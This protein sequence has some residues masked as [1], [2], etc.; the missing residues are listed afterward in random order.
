[1][2]VW[3]EMCNAEIR[4]ELLTELHNKLSIAVCSPPVMEEL[5][6]DGHCTAEW[7]AV[8]WRRYKEYSTQEYLR[9]ANRLAGGRGQAVWGVVVH[10]PVFWDPRWRRASARC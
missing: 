10:L 1:M 5:P 3:L 2:R 4:R 6:S 9:R 8:A 7:Q